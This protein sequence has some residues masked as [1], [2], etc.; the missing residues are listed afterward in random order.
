MPANIYQVIYLDIQQMRQF[1]NKKSP[2]HD[3]SGLLIFS[4]I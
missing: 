2:E 3:G 1:E 4:T